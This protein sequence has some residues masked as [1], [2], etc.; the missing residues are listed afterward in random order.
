MSGEISTTMPIFSTDAPL[1]L[2]NHLQHLRE[3]SGITNKF[4]SN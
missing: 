3:G 2:E 1:L 4:I